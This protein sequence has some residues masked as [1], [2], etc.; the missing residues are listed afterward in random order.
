MSFEG[1]DFCS[2]VSALVQLWQ[3]QFH[4]SAVVQLRDGKPGDVCTPLPSGVSPNWCGQFKDIGVAQ[5]ISLQ[6]EMIREK[7]GRV[8]F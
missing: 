6:E 4:L 7:P 5:I 1:G 2:E 8:L 3:F